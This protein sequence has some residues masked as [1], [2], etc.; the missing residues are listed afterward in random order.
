MSKDPTEVRVALTGNVWFDP[1]LSATIVT[2]IN[3]APT[4]TAKNLGYT[5]ADGVTFNVA[6]NTVDIDGWQTRDP[7]R[8][9]VENE[10]RSCS[11]TLRQ[12]SGDIWLSTFGGSIE[13]LVAAVTGPPAEP[14]VYRWT[15]DEG[16]LPE[17]M[18]WVDFDDELPD[19]QAVRYRFGFKRA[20]QSDAVEFTGKRTDA[21]NLPNN[22]RALA[23]IGGG[24]GFYLDTNDPSFDIA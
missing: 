4:V 2:D 19:G 12:T 16:K 14:A 17:G 21:L 10:P 15:P 11:F 3:L 23:P 6:R 8:I 1:S 18:L 7:L 22:W 20:A 9:L 13:E 24:S 5:T